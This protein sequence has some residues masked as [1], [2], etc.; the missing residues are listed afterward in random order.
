MRQTTN[1]QRTNNYPNIEPSRFS[2]QWLDWGVWQIWS[3]A[4]FNSIYFKVIQTAGEARGCSIKS[5][6]IKGN[7]TIADLRYGEEDIVRPNTLILAPIK[8]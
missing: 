1:E 6:V 8:S 2:N 3:L 4:I 7:R 5:L